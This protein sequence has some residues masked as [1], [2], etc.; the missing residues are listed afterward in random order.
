MACL[1][2]VGG[3]QTRAV[4][5]QN[6]VLSLAIKATVLALAV[7]GPATLWMAVAADMGAS[8]LV[9]GNGLRLVRAS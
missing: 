3:L 4:I 6:I 9:I 5:A 8:L 1:T 7:A 2:F